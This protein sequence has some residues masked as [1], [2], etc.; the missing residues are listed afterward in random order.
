MDIG[1]F[2][3]ILKTHEMMP[4]ELQLEDVVFRFLKNWALKA[5][6]QSEKGKKHFLLS[7]KVNQDGLHLRFEGDEG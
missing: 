1:R 6:E 4:S 5:Y 3:T 7:C 2:V